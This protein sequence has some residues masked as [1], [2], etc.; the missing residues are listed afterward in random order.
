PRPRTPTPSRSGPP[1]PGVPRLTAP[2]G[3][4]GGAVGFAPRGRIAPA[5]RGSEARDPS[6]P[7]REAARDTVRRGTC[8]TVPAPPI[9]PTAA[10]GRTGPPTRAQ[11]SGSSRTASLISYPLQVVA[12]GVAA[13]SAPRDEL[14][15]DSRSM[16]R[17]TWPIHAFSRVSYGHVAAPAGRPGVLTAH[18]SSA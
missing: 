1:P 16:P 15:P 5:A 18:Q 17:R 2:P 14:R 3:P 4:P 9:R 8:A 12:I 7:P 10:P 6:S 11:S 13:R